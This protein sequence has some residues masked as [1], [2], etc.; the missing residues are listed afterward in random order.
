MKII[1]FHIHPYLSREE[2]ACMYQE[3]FQLSWKEAMED[4]KRAGIDHV[5]GS[6]AIIGAYNKTTGQQHMQD[7]NKRALE[8]EKI[9]DGFYT[10]GFHIHP[11]YVEDSL[12]TIEFMHEN[13]Y[14]LI[15]ELIPYMHGWADWGF[16]YAS[17]AL[18]KILERAGKY[19]MAVNY[20][21]MLEQ[22]EQME[23]MIKSHPDVT[24]VAAHPGQKEDCVKHFDRMERYPNAY[25][26]LSGT[27]IFRYGMIREGI[28]RVGRERFLFG[29]D[30]PITN[31][32]MYVE[33]VKF[34]HITDEDREAVFHKNAERILKFDG[35]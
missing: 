33:A 5:C 19:H 6:V 12:E 30:Y 13:G 15:G 21:T 10:P 16:D 1:D 28:H 8:I 11:A 17:D 2:N 25:L 31:P 4:L 26:D 24:F 20:H 3:N 18:G 23:E 34:E 22:Q 27:G 9:C 7:M 29:T 14:N 32:G 35:K